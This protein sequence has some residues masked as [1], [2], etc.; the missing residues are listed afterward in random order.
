MKPLEEEEGE[1]LSSSW[2]LYESGGDTDDILALGKLKREVLLE[3]LEAVR[4]GSL[5][6]SRRVISMWAY[7]WNGRG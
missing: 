7:H 1:S 4:A 3:S 6:L 2:V 5:H